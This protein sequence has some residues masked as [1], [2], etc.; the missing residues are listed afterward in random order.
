MNTFLGAHASSVLTVSRLLTEHARCLRSQGASSPITKTRR[1]EES[2]KISRRLRG[3]IFF[4]CCWVAPCSSVV[5]IRVIR[6]K[7]FRRRFFPLSKL[8]ERATVYA[9]Y[10]AAS[11]ST[12]RHHAPV[13]LRITPACRVLPVRLL[14]TPPRR[15]HWGRF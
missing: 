11:R 15:L 7:S 1:R 12:A 9:L 3:E 8:T 4:G 5:S 2:Q 10:L 6:G 14:A 13:S